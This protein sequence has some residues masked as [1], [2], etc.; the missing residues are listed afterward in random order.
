MSIIEGKE[1]KNLMQNF[2]LTSLISHGLVG[3]KTEK[4][5]TAVGDWVSRKA[6]SSKP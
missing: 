2:N 4:V 5:K 6:E 3:L 1:V